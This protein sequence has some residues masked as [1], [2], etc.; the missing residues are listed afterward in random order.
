[1]KKQ[2]SIRV[3]NDLLSQ[4]TEEALRTNQTRGSYIRSCIQKDLNIRSFR[5]L[6]AQ[7]IPIAEK[8]G[9]LTD[10]DVFKAVS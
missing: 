7:L 9:L 3:S 6:R 8:K 1:M 4:I 10:E 2:I 5:A